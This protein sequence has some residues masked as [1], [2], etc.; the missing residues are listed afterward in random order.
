MTIYKA[1]Q[2]FFNSKIFNNVEI[3][4]KNGKI[5]TLKDCIPASPS[6]GKSTEQILI[7]PG[8]VDIQLNGCNGVLFRGDSD[9]DTLKTMEKGNL[10]HGVTSFLPT[11]ITDSD[12]NIISALN[13]VEEV[14]NSSVVPSVKGMHLE[15]PYISQTHSGAHDK[16]LIRRLD[17]K[18][19]EK[20]CE[21]GN[22]SVLKVITIAPEIVSADQIHKLKSSNIMVFLGHSA[23]DTGTIQHAIKAGAT[24]ITHLYNG[25]PPLYGRHPSLL[26]QAFTNL[27]LSAGI[28]ADFVHVDK[29]SIAIAK[30]A[31]KDRLYAVTDATATL[32]N[33]MKEFYFGQGK[34]TFEDGKIVTDNGSL[35]G[36][37]LTMETACNNLSK[38]FSL[39]ESLA[40]CSC[41]P[42][43]AAGIDAGVLKQD[44]Q[45]DFNIF[46]VQNSSSNSNPS[47]KTVEL[48]STY[49]NG[50]L[51]LKKESI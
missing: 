26:G 31:M 45:A 15:G 29:V 36:S 37:C 23:A 18:M 11:L 41:H 44:S 24:S 28:I 46:K 17:T 8:F 14:M 49:L 22:R 51:V 33:P 6:L 43:L 4:I 20:L 9:I 35:A 16:S 32:D 10:K 30:T 40:M 39:E 48:V 21:F 27:N 5:A 38:L 34:C 2:G 7:A 42:A 3:D 50:Q 25:M 19:L 47:I 1:N 12:D 13:L